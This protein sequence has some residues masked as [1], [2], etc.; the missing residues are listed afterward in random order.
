MGMLRMD[1][2]MWTVIACLPF[3]AVAVCAVLVWLI[4]ARARR[5][6]VHWA[7]AAAL[8][9]LAVTEVGNGLDLW[10]TTA[11]EALRGRRIALIGELLMPLG[12]LIFSLSFAKSA[13]ANLLRE[14]RSGLWS[15]G[16]LTAMFLSVAWS[17]RFFFVVGG[18]S[19][20]DATISLGPTG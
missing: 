6:P 1:N 11:A 10:S 4:L 9:A 20:V 12:W 7:F 16:L 5:E 3:V 2:T 15:T 17:D 19:A 14:W 8:A 13:V 18:P